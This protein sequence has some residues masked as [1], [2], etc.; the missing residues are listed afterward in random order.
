[1]N[2]ADK[3]R[4]FSE[5]RRVLKPQSLFAVYDIMQVGEGSIAYPTPWAATAATGFVEPP[6]SYRR[7][8]KAT[9][10]EIEREIDRRDFCLTLARP[11]ERPGLQ[12]EIHSRQI[13]RG[14]AG[15][16][17]CHLGAG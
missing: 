16:D 4:L 11:A 3:A 2:I 6:D 5:V 7:L 17:N 10:F 13:R 12:Y 1:M 8:L 14:E 9:G 15:E